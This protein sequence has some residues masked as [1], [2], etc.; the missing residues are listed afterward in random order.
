MMQGIGTLEASQEAS[1]LKGVDSAV[2]LEGDQDYLGD[3]A[4]S[5]NDLFTAT[6][7]VQCESISI[8]VTY[9]RIPTLTHYQH[10]INPVSMAGLGG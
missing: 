2:Q 10:Y 6:A 1:I 9:G 8:N 4:L 5:S 7:L 3:L